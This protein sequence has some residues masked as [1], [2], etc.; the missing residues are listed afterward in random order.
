VRFPLGAIP[1]SVRSVMIVRVTRTVEEMK[2]ET[3]VT[4]NQWQVIL[5]PITQLLITLLHAQH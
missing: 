5:K 1:A 4:L 2:R 3:N